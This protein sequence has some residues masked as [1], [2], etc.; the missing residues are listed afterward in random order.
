MAGVTIL[1]AS[2]LLAYLND[3]DV[4]HTDADA[5]L[6]APGRRAASTLTLAES[7]VSA[8]MANRLENTYAA[9]ATLEVDEVAIAPGAAPELARL[10]AETGLPLPDCCV[11]HAAESVDAA[12]IAPR[13]SRLRGIAAAR[14]YEIP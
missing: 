12:A 6:S 13:D 7:L 3:A 8:A 10:R 1:D 11:L 2:I 4:H 5:I 14:G 9:F